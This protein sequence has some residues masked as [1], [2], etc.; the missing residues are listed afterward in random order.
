[1]LS[2]NALHLCQYQF[3]IKLKSVEVESN[4]PNRVLV[5]YFIYIKRVL[6]ANCLYKKVKIGILFAVT[7]DLFNFM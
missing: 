5:F 7:L 2:G 3:C 1:M 4:W 6:D